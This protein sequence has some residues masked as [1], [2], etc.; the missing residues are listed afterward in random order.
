MR[1]ALFS[2]R[3]EGQGKLLSGSMGESNSM[4]REKIFRETLRD[5][6]RMKFW[7]LRRNMEGCMRSNMQHS[8]MYSLMQVSTLRF[9]RINIFLST[10]FQDISSR[11]RTRNVW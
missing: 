11:E 1:L 4:L 2:T 5:C 10:V 3:M 6:G 9:L 8:I 7:I